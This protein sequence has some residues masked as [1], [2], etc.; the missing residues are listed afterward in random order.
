MFTA[1]C[2]VVLFS[3]VLGPPERANGLTVAFTA[4]RLSL[5]ALRAARLLT[6][7]AATWTKECVQVS[8]QG[9]HE[10]GARHAY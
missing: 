10:K 7:L 6:A 2:S 8:F 4:I 1:Q 3:T 9:N 5:G